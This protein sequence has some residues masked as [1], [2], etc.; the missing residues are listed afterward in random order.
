MSVINEKYV[1]L[2]SA[3]SANK[4]TV[5][6]FVEAF[7]SHGEGNPTVEALNSFLKNKEED[8]SEQAF[9]CVASGMSFQHQSLIWARAVLNTYPEVSSA[10]LGTTNPR[11]SSEQDE[12]LTALFENVDE[13]VR[14][15]HVDMN[16]EAQLSDAIE[17]ALALSFEFEM[18]EDEDVPAII[19]ALEG[20]MQNRIKWHECNTVSDEFLT[21]L[22]A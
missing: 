1:E 10:L 19:N 16:G 21:Q 8:P 3:L 5:S 2:T 13:W 22:S 15:N 17:V 4:T 9:D 20:V 12:Q 6:N 14:V 7:C 18:D 11:S